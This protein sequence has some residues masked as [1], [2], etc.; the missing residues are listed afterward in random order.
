[1]AGRGWG[2]TRTGAEWIRS[3]VEG[4]QVKWIALVGRTAADVRDVMVEG[5]SGIMRTAPPWNRPLYEPAKRRVT[6]PKYG[7]M[8]TTYSADEPNAL[9]GPQH[10]I[11]WL[12]ELAAWKYP[13]EA[14]ENFDLG[15]RMGE[16]PRAIV[17]TTPRPIKLVR[18]LLQDKA[19]A[20][21]RGST[22]EN[23]GNLSRETLGRYRDR[24]EGT[25]MGRQELHAELLD[26]LAGALWRRDM[27]EKHRVKR[28]PDMA[29][30]VVAIDPAVSSGDDS[31]ETGIVVAGKG[32]DGHGY[33]LDDLSCRLSPDGWAR[34][35]VN[36][37]ESFKADRI[38]A[39]VNQ[40]G[41]LVERVI[42]TVDPRVAYRAV[43]ASKGK[44]TRAE[45]ISALYEQGKVHHV[46]MLAELEDQMCSY[47]PDGFD[48]SPDHLDAAV[49]A[50]T[51]LMLGAG[52]PIY[53]KMVGGSRSSSW[54]E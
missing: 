10:Q 38:V 44:R 53:S 24:Y 31:N 25:R 33:V 41:D 39:E 26:D 14:W 52:V 32:V 49:W 7:A 5:P 3:Q 15:L 27:I 50:L 48:G 19:V 35:A 36:A 46:G 1:M 28:A 13:D 17:T 47:M 2:K 20:V 54:R 6:W 8:A 16:H 21:T 42:K 12:D 34:R 51:D 29:R 45:P 43:H 37:Y 11:A 4:G 22:F 18:Q 30:I 9:R 23:A 40:G